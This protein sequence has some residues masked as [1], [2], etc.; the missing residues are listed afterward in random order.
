MALSQLAAFVKKGSSGMIPKEFM[1]KNLGND[2]QDF[3]S[4]ALWLDFHDG[5]LVL[6]PLLN[7]ASILRIEKPETA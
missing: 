1:N 7:E 6:S 3:S 2:S 4:H 5:S